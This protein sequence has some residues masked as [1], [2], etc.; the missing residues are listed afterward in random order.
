MHKVDEAVDEI[1][2]QKISYD[3]SGWH[4]YEQLQLLASLNEYC[5]VDVQFNN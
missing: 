2:T 3:Y 5:V 1:S 4:S